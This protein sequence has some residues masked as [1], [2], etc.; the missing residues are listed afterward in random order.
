MTVVQTEDGTYKVVD[1]DGALA[2]GFETSSA[3]WRWI[4]RHDGSPLN[5]SEN[6]AEWLWQQRL[7]Q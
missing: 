6:T 1:G 7:E 5:R 2:W 3:A 4:D